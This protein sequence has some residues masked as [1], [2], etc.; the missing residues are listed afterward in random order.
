MSDEGSD[1]ESE[2]EFFEVDKIVDHKVEVSRTDRHVVDTSLF[3][4]VGTLK[5]LGVLLAFIKLAKL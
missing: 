1:S 5:E 4:D 3:E 2:G